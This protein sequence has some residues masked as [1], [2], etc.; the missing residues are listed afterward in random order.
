MLTILSLCVVHEAV[1]QGGF[2]GEIAATV[3]EEAM[4]SL[5]APILRF[6]APFCPV[7]PFAPSQES[8]VRIYPEDISKAI[9]KTI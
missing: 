4:D 1:K 5:K 3:A 2:G 8:M 9:L 7:V 6:G